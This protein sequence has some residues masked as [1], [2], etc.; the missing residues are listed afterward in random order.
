[1]KNTSETT[2]LP[3]GGVD[4]AEISANV[5][6]QSVTVSRSDIKKESMFKKFLAML[7]NTTVTIRTTA[8][9]DISSGQVFVDNIQP[10]GIISPNPSRLSITLRNVGTKNVYIGSYGVTS[11]TG[12]LLRS[13]ESLTLDKTWGALY[14][15]S[16]DV[17]GSVIA[18]IEE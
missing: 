12:F 3:G 9:E 17:A 14:G 6:G 5:A 8:R 13:Y 11:T 16:D 18:F 7:A 1:M 4:L 2:G 15:I 10:R